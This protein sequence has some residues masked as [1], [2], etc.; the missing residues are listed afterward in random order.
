MGVWREHISACY[1]GDKKILFLAWKR[2]A[3]EWY[4]KET[5][6]L[7]IFNAEKQL[8]TRPKVK[9]RTPSFTK[10]Q[11]QHLCMLE[12][13][14]YIITQDTETCLVSV[15]VLDLAVMK[16]CGGVNISWNKTIQICFLYDWYLVIA[17]LGEMIT[18]DLSSR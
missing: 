1:E 9:G 17:G 11:T 15:H 4:N 5:P 8:W 12:D 10:T 3:F 7:F 14:A 13:R 2:S 18:L 6:K 16:W